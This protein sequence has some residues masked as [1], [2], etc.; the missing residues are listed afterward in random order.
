M[1][2]SLT[3]GNRFMMVGAGIGKVKQPAAAQR[4]TKLILQ[5]GGRP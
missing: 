3:A 5:R 4:K 1:N 2:S